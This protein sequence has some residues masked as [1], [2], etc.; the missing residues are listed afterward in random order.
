MYKAVFDEP[1]TLPLLLTVTHVTIITLSSLWTRLESTPSPSPVEPI[2]GQF[3][4]RDLPFR[5]IV[6]SPAKNGP[7]SGLGCYSPVR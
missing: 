2:P 7:E 1:E 6:P 5:A 3:Q 4:F